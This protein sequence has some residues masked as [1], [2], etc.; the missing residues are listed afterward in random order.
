MQT[1]AE[2]AKEYATGATPDSGEAPKYPYGLTLCLGDDS[3]EKLGMVAP[4]VGAEVMVM[5][6]AK[7]TSVSEREEQDGGKCRNVDLQITDMR[8]AP[9]DKMYPNSDMK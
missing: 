1:S 2:K 8:V 6:K 5:A 9:A 4:A 3:L 7:V